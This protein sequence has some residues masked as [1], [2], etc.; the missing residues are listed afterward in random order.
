[1]PEASFLKLQSLF[2]CIV[3]LCKI[4]E[5]KGVC[6]L[7][8]NSDVTSLFPTEA[9]SFCKKVYKTNKIRPFWTLLTNTVQIQFDSH[10]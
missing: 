5:D 9:Y 3:S 8:F 6:A 2:I 1:M 7:P 10:N 4:G